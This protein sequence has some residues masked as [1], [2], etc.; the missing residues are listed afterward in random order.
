MADL[1]IAELREIGKKMTREPWKVDVSENFGNDWPIT[2]GT[3]SIDGKV[4]HVCTDNLRASQIAGNDYDAKTD[5]EGIAQMRN[6][7]DSLLDRLEAAEKPWVKLTKETMPEPKRNAEFSDGVAS[8]I[9]WYSDETGC[10]TWLIVNAVV[11]TPI[12]EFKKFRML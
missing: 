1:T 12:E 8:V 2:T 5:A 11:Q 6:L 4:Y 9:G 10:V 7:W 3:S